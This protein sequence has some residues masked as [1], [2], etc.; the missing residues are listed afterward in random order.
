M[1]RED[2]DARLADQPF[3]PFRMHLTDKT[4]VEVLG[5]GDCM[6]G[7]NTVVCP[8]GYAPDEHGRRWPRAFR[9]V[10]IPHIV[11]IEDVPVKSNGSRR[12]K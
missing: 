10:A 6:V 11:R 8:T 2:I 9:K 4:V 5:G 3:Q 12:K 1:T 7:L